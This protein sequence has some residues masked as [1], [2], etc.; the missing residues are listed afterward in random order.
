M[1]LG[2]NFAADNPDYQCRGARRL[3]VVSSGRPSCGVLEM[4]V[5]MSTFGPWRWSRISTRAVEPPRTTAL[6][7]R[8]RL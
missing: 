5:V 6:S 3:K 8:L 2:D 4:S 1:G 7:T